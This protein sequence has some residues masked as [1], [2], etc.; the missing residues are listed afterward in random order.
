M[1]SIY[2]FLGP[3]DRKDIAKRVEGLGFR[4]EET[5]KGYEKGKTHIN[6]T[7][8]NRGTVEIQFYD[9][10]RYIDIKKGSKQYKTLERLAE[11]L[12]PN[13]ITNAA[14][15]EIFQELPRRQAVGYNIDE[16]INEVLAEDN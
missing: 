1:T 4:K 5:F 14:L 7:D 11:I 15:T 9:V 13:K 10:E 16:I 8:K 3:Y 6:L 12:H 2:F